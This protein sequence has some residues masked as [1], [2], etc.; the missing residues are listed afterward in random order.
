[1]NTN[2]GNGWFVYQNGNASGYKY[3][4]EWYLTRGEADIACGR[5]RDSASCERWD[6]TAEVRAA[7]PAGVA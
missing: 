1:M 4:S 6:P 7:P 3:A 5:I 2:N